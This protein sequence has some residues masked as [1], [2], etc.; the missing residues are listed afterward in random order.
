MEFIAWVDMVGGTEKAADI[1][2]E[3]ERTVKSWYACERTPRKDA[4]DNIVKKT[5]GAVDYNGI[6]Q[7]Q[8]K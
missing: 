7:K 1:L 4:A 5:H 3:K 2:E 6:F 8:K